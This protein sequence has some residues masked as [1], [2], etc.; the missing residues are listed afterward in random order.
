MECIWWEWDSK[1]LSI[2]KWEIWSWRCDE[3]ENSL[4]ERREIFLRTFLLVVSSGYFESRLK[5][6]LIGP[7]TINKQ[8]WRSINCYAAYW[9]ILHQ[10]IYSHSFLLPH[11]VIPLLFSFSLVTDKMNTYFCYAIYL[12][13]SVGYY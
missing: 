11:L 13:V 9:K 3:K 6:H 10:S 7:F 5:F 4:R 2:R 1:M 12:L 8:V